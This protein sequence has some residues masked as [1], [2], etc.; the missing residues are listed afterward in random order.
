MGT[1][2]SAGF[3]LQNIRIETFVMKKIAILILMLAC[4]ISAHER[5]D[6][7]QAIRE[8]VESYLTAWRSCNTQL[9]VEAFT[10]DADWINSFGVKKKGRQEL[11]SFL[12][13]IFSLPNAKERKDSEII[14]DIRFIRTDVALVSSD[15]HVEKQK[16]TTGE[17]MANRKGHILRVL[18]KEDEK[19]QIISMMIMDEKPRLPP[20]KQ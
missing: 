9:I 17:E 11:A 20:E 3:F 2:A 1:S 16:Y 12:D 8:V 5:K 10:D 18:V 19:W 7:E 13:W 4:K 14:T 15:F 6:D